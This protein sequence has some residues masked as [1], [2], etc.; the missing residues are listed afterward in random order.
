[1]KVK[2]NRTKLEQDFSVAGYQV[3]FYTLES[4]WPNRNRTVKLLDIRSSPRREVVKLFSLA[5]PVAG[6]QHLGQK[7][8]KPPSLHVTAAAGLRK[9][10]C[11]KQKKI[12]LKKITG[13]AVIWIFPFLNQMS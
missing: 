11:S 3:Q 1:M 5:A 6:W 2:I 4:V 9:F 10:I 12:A 7:V 8:G 13:P